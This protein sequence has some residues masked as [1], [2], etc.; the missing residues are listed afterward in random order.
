MAAKQVFAETKP[1]RN[2][3]PLHS[4]TSAAQFLGGVSHW[5]IRA[6]LRDGRLRRTKVG[7]RTFVRQSELEKIIQDQ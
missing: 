6:Y 1:A 3:D 5:T 4:V 7:A 2:E